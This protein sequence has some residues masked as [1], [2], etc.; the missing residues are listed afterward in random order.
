MI[1]NSRNRDV[2]AGGPAVRRIKALTGADGQSLAPGALRIPATVFTTMTRRVPNC[3]HSFTRSALQSHEG[4][5]R[6]V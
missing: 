6:A 5:L 4:V 2:V 3:A 1:A